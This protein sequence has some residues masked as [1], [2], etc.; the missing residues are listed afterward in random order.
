MVRRLQHPLRNSA[1]SFPIIGHVHDA[2]RSRRAER[3]YSRAQG[4]QQ[5]AGDPGTRR[6]RG[7]TDGAERT[8]QFWKFCCSAR[9][10]APRQS[11]MVWRFR[12]ASCRSSAGCSA[13]FARLRR[14]DRFRSARRP[15]G[16]PDFS[17]ARAGS[18][19]RRSSQGAGARRASAARSG[20]R[21][22][23]ARSRATPT[24][25]TP[26]WRCHRPARRRKRPAFV[27]A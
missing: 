27:R 10:S 5:E 17:A 4:Q 23:V 18:R 26:C 19:R 12:T 8:A 6:A 1:L 9:S 24:R 11:A 25:S 13:L 21:A 15:A 22:E 3:G 7:R 20:D 14:G 2:Y 16:R